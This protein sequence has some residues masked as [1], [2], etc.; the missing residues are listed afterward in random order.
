MF[1]KNGAKIDNMSQSDK[2]L[3]VLLT[4]DARGDAKSAAVTGARLRF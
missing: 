4:L 2:L 1:I 3:F